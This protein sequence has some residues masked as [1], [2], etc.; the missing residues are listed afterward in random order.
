MRK[1]S[2]PGSTGRERE[3]A[4]AADHGGHAVQRRR[5]QRLIPE[6]LRVVVRV[7][8][9]E[10]GNER[11]AVGVDR[12][13]RALV[14]ASERHDPPVA[15]ADVGWPRRRTGSVDDAAVADEHI[16]HLRVLPR[17]RRAA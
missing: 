8:V 5:R 12:A 10:P 17:D 7:Q 15:D 2:S 1:S 6:D 13:A 9:D 16:E 4:V 11:E 3:A 14:D